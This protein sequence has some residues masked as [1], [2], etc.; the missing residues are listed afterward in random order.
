M[1]LKEFLE[2]FI[3]PNSQ[4]RLWQKEKEGHKMI[5]DNDHA[6]MEHE[7]LRYNTVLSEYLNNEVEHVFSVLMYKSQS[8]E[9]INISIK[10]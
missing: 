1:T 4:I 9:A 5:T 8:P 10:L 7:I 6:L 2:T 3:E